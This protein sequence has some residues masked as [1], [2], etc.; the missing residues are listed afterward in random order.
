MIIQGTVYVFRFLALA[1]T[2]FPD[3][4]LS[5]VSDPVA[6][7]LD[8]NLMYEAFRT[9]TM[10]RKTCGDMM[11]SGHTS[12]LTSMSLFLTQYA[13]GIIPRR[14]PRILLIVLCWATSLAGMVALLLTRLHYT[15]DIWV[16]VLVVVVIFTSY[17]SLIESPARVQ[18]MFF[19]G[20]YEVA[21]A[22]TPLKE[23]S[24]KP[25]PFSIP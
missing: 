8:E 9:F 11:F 18:G 12:V 25:V 3:P 1:L 15:F 4:S 5:C 23:S 21:S 22:Y 2:I 13:R 17:H 7:T 19:I 16:S 6:G 10:M 24:G 14:L 20:W